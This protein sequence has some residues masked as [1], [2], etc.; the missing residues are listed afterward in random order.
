MSGNSWETVLFRC[1]EDIKNGIT[2]LL[3]YVNS[4]KGLAGIRDAMWELLTSEAASHSWEVVCRRLLEKPLLFWEDMMRQ[5]F[6][7]RL[8][9]RRKIT[10]APC[11]TASPG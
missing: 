10:R 5:L 8:Q 6:L 4:M 11:F 3:M 1:N 7:D 9:V 2:N